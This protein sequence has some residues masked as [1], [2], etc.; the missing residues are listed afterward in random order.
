MN[1]K[2]LFPSL[3]VGVSGLL[4]AGSILLAQR[5]QPVQALSQHPGAIVSAWRQVNSDGFADGNNRE[6]IRFAVHGDYLFVSTEN[7]VTGGEVWRSA[8]GTTW[9]QVNAD[10]F[11]VSSNLIAFVEGSFN[12]FLY[13]GTRS[14]ATGAEIW[15]CITCN[16]SDWTRVVSDGFGDSNNHTV[17]RIMLFANTLYATVDN[18]VTGVEVWT[19]PTGAADSWTQR[20]ADGFGNPQN[21][22]AWAAAL[23]DDYLYVATAMAGDWTPPDAFGVEVWR[24]DGGDSWVKVTPAGFGG[25]ENV[26]W[27]LAPADGKLYLSLGNFSGAQLWRCGLCDGSDWAHVVDG[28]FGTNALAT[29]VVEYQH[30]LVAATSTNWELGEDGAGIWISADGVHWAQTSSGGFGDLH[31]AKVG[32]GGIV[33][34]KGL[35]YLGTQNESTGAEVWQSL[36]QLYLPLVVR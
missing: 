13:A 23:F 36:K 30:K 27:D 3:A 24:T 35:L 11:G 7:L 21:V 22:G 34:Y 18:E 16:G 1:R 12:G 5:A 33:E 19:S 14:N 17:Q 9:E 32:T 10:G 4:I 26:A 25:R 15:R 20:N 6:A 29:V 31:N 8:N 28:T 2:M